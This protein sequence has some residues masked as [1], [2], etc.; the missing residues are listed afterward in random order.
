M[1]DPIADLMKIIHI[2]LE[3]GSTFTKIRK[4]LKK[5]KYTDSMIDDLFKKYKKQ[6]APFYIRN[7]QFIMVSGVMILI[8]L[9]IFGLISIS[10]S[11]STCKSSSCFLEVANNC[12]KATFEQIEDTVTVE[13]SADNCILTK[14]IVA[15]GEEEPQEVKDLFKNQEMTCV[16]A[17]GNFNENQIL[18]F[19]ED[20][21]NCEGSLK[22]IVQQ[23]RI[24]GIQQ[25]T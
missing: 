4:E 19:L 3:K 25:L 1:R 2:S 17:K 9:V 16:Y 24:A 12:D 21:E 14:K 5:A 18:G 22:E 6:Q 23:L 15:M 7:K 10:T 20:I 13:Y 11:L 8:S